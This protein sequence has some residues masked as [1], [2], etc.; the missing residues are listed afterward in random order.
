[1]K[2]TYP[3]CRRERGM[4]W[5]GRALCT[6]HFDTR[7]RED[8]LKKLNVVIRRER[9]ENRESEENSDSECGSAL[10]TNR[11]GNDR[12]DRYRS[13]QRTISG[14]SRESGEGEDQRTYALP[15]PIEGQSIW[16]QLFY[17]WWR[18]PLGTRSLG[19]RDLVDR[20]IARCSMKT[21]VKMAGKPVILKCC[22]PPDYYVEE[23]HPGEGPLVY[24]LCK[25]HRKKILPFLCN[26]NS[27]IKILPIS[28]VY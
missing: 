18:S 12:S 11:T 20:N 5:L 24:Y 27:V 6:Y 23:D 9:N 4:I 13:S 15:I 10:P 7:S 8:L 26:L 14:T 28:P 25:A 16:W 2:C 21:K 19:S 17:H 1:M 22:L 3:K